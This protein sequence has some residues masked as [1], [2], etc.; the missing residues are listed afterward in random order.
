M[1]RTA[2]VC[3]LFLKGACRDKSAEY[4]QLKVCD[5][6]P[7]VGIST[8]FAF[9]NVLWVATE[10]REFFIRGGLNPKSEVKQKQIDEV[11]KI[12]QAQNILKNVKM[13]DWIMKGQNDRKWEKLF[14]KAESEDH[15]KYRM[16]LGT[17]WAVGLS[18]NLY[19][20]RIPMTKEMVAKAVAFLNEENRQAFNSE[21]IYKENGYVWDVG[22]NN[23]MHTAYNALAAAGMW[24]KKQIK[25]SKLQILTSKI[26][27]GNL[28]LAVPFD[29]FLRVAKHGAQ[30]H[31]PEVRNLDREV[32]ATVE[33][34]GWM[35]QQPGT[36]LVLYPIHKNNNVFFNPDSPHAFVKDQI[37][38][39]LDL[40]PLPIINATKSRDTMD[41]LFA[42]KENT[43]LGANLYFSYRRNYEAIARPAS[44]VVATDGDIGGST[45]AIENEAWAAQFNQFLVGLTT[46][47]LD[48]I[49]QFRKIKFGAN[50]APVK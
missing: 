6:G 10:G 2:M 30:K 38:S 12:A 44:A 24:A 32:I 1:G 46:K 3:V 50:T 31:I 5:N 18:R 36:M 9:K 11:I 40:T 26:T 42:D 17:D 29:T 23:C 33:K 34:S 16:S 27:D 20:S 41:A 22:L 19:C 39:F 45:K 21:G 14:G 7:G 47:N 15:Y 8:Y 37:S 28:S 43:D 48:L 25:S 4:P 13:H 49:N 35:L